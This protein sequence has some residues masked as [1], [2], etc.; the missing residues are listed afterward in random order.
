MGGTIPDVTL[1]RDSALTAAFRDG[2]GWGDDPGRDSFPGFGTDCGVPSFLNPSLLQE[3]RQ[4]SL[5]VV[6]D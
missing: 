1:S 4:R 3:G 5:P 6:P 2:G